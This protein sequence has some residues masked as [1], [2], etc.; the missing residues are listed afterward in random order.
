LTNMVLSNIVKPWPIANS[1]NMHP[2]PI[3]KHIS[4]DGNSTL[5]IDYYDFITIQGEKMA[6]W[7]TCFITTKIYVY[8]LTFLTNRNH[9]IASWAPF[10]PSEM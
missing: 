5:V 2:P 4:M 6:F 9:S 8:N 1:K 3:F 10:Q 7:I